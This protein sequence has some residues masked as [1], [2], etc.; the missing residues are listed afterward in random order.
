MTGV[1]LILI[2]WVGVRAQEITY[3]LEP[4]HELGPELWSIPIGGK[5]TMSADGTRMLVASIADSAFYVVD[6]E[7]GEYRNLG[8]TYDRQ[9]VEYGVDNDISTLVTWSLNVV[10][11]EL[12]RRYEVRD[13]AADT[14]IHENDI[15]TSIRAVSRL[16]NRLMANRQL[17]E[18]NTHRLIIDYND[19]ANGFGAWFDD[20]RGLLYRAMPR[21]MQEIDPTDGRVLRTWGIRPLRSEVRR[22]SNS[23]WLYV[24]SLETDFANPQNWV[25]AINLV[26]GERLTF[27]KYFWERVDGQPIYDPYGWFG[28]SSNGSA[29]G[30]G[31]NAGVDKRHYNPVWSFS[32]DEHRTD[33]IVDHSFLFEGGEGNKLQSITPD[34][35]VLLHSWRTNWK[36]S[37]ITRCNALVP[38]STSVGDVTGE[39]EPLG[40]STYVAD[41]FLHVE[42]EQLE[43]II[44]HVDVATVD[45]ALVLQEDI[46]DPMLPVR[47]PIGHLANGTYL[48]SVQTSMG[49]FSSTFTIQR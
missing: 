22:P 45:G 16:Q 13:I 32:A 29:V 49:R 10:D 11:G 43:T 48:C 47:F 38:V 2:G 26:T 20:D 36:D 12:E 8:V 21:M 7:T 3:N 15:G 42:P 27:E 17:I 40:V 35:A 19:G 31:Q 9:F 44:Q 33:V 25:E 46:T 1:L 37:S 5:L 34:L 23:D 14:V 18:L 6:V 24:F 4:T 28:V 30:S 41:D 39:G